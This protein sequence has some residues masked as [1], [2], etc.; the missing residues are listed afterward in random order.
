MKVGERG[1]L[2][3]GVKGSAE[4]GYNDRSK[5][6]EA[7]VGG[8]LDAKYAHKWGGGQGNARGK[9]QAGTRAGA[10]AEGSAGW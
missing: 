2:A 6:Y 1:R 7:K 4:A 5:S 3:G 10:K 8:K 9:F